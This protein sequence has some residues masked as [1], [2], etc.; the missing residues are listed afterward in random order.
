MTLVVV[1]ATRCTEQEFWETSPLGQSLTRLAVDSRISSMIA[2]S[3]QTGLPLVYNHCL[4][5]MQGD[6][7]AV[8]IHDD[9]W[10]EDFALYEHLQ[11][12]LEVFDMV[13]VAGNKRRFPGQPAWAFLDTQW[14]WDDDANLSG[15]I[16]HGDYPFAPVDRFGPLPS[17][18]ELLDGVFLGVQRSTLAKAGI[19]FDERFSF[20]FY[21]MD[22]CRQLRQ[23][24]LRIGTWPISIT[25]Q[26]SGGY[27]SDH[28][29]ASYS[30]YLAKWG[31]QKFAV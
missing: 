5:L 7:M 4:S 30:T 13:G 10:I 23:A 16:G 21:D 27:E 12:G 22:F 15:L 29:R 28:W 24:G 14:T 8:F 3:N 20:H 31:E 2:F 26:S 19:R 6:P 18:C 9:V 11:A 17:E 25:H 1:S